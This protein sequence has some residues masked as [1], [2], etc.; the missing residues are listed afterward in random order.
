M[1][2]FMATVFAGPL[3]PSL[4]NTRLLHDNWWLWG[5]L[6]LIVH[7]TPYCVE[8]LAYIILVLCNTELD[9]TFHI[10]AVSTESI[11]IFLYVFYILIGYHAIVPSRVLC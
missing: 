8:R 9:S 11:T 3:S 1:S 4:V 2:G 6:Y 7:Y 10:V 5:K